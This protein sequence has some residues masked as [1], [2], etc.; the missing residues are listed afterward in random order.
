VKYFVF[1]A[2]IIANRG[3]KLVTY[4]D[5]RRQ[6]FFN[7]VLVENS[8]IPGEIRQ[9]CAQP[10]ADRL[11]MSYG[12][13]SVRQPLTPIEDWWKSPLIAASFHPNL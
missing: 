4:G 5:C 9:I 10:Q 11:Q 3:G 2:Q 7:A 13:M 6:V 1:G 12:G 8:L